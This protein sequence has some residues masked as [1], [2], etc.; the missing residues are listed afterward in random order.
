M[1]AYFSRAMPMRDFIVEKILLRGSA[2][3][4]SLMADLGLTRFPG[5]LTSDLSKVA[6]AAAL[7]QALEGLQKD[8]II[9]NVAKRSQGYRGVFE[10]ANA[11]SARAYVSKRRFRFGHVV[12]QN[13]AVTDAKKEALRLALL[14]GKA[15]PQQSPMVDYRPLFDARGKRLDDNCSLGARCTTPRL[16]VPK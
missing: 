14:Y 12:D 8:W 7:R 15:T 13:A 10:M 16:A 5:A 1:S 3:K 2:T 11:P 9:A 6:A 4:A